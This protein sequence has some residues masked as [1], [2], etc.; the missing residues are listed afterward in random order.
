[1]RFF[2]DIS[3]LFFPNL[4]LSCS[5][6]LT[7]NEKYLCTTCRFELPVLSYTDLKNNALENIFTGRIPIEQATALLLYRKKGI[8]KELIYHLK[9]NGKQSIGYFFADW[10][11]EE[12]KQSNRFKNIDYI[13]PVPLHSKRFKERGYN[14]LDFFGKRLSEILKI[15]YRKD[16]LLKKSNTTKQS[17]KSRFARMEKKDAVFY[18]S[19]TIDL[20]NKHILLLDD[21][22]TTGATIESCFYG[23]NQFDAIKV[24][25]AVMAYTKM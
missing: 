5:A 14:Q 13:V 21:I 4:C 7:Q 8:V 12:I 18:L 23:L 22:V 1:M 20:S 3:N 19:P 24:S 2:K 10:L 25:I 11:G 15:P 6:I 16:I 17:K 9:Y